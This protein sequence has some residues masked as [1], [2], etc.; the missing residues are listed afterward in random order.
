MA[1]N[2]SRHDDRALTILQSEQ[3][4][5]RRTPR[6]RLHAKGMS[7]AVARRMRRNGSSAIRL[8]AVIIC[9]VL[10][11]RAA[12]HWIVSEWLSTPPAPRP[13]RVAAPPAARSRAKDSASLVARNIFCSG[14]RSGPPGPSGD[15]EAIV[16]SELPIELVSTMFCPS[17]PAW[18]VAMLRDRSIGASEPAFYRRGMRITS[19][20]AIV[21]SV[22][23]R[24]VY[25]RR[26][27]RL[28]YLEL[29]G[30]TGPPAIAHQAGSREISCNGSSCEIERSLV[31]R[32]LAN[33][34]VLAATA[35][36][37]PGAGGLR[38][39]AIQR[40]SLL[41]QLGLQPGDVVRS[42]NKMELSSPENM[43]DILIKLRH[44]SQ[45][46]VAVERQGTRLTLDY[47]IR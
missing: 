2:R 12:A 10:S 6:N 47:T 40:G 38:L 31:E 19:T 22:L 42:V 36:V 29:D 17:D 11:G 25:V 23:T 15:G 21:A 7:V 44:A 39:E 28:E 43:L 16:R 14:C 4:A 24:R 45:L 9:A 3:H 20:D 46:S 33:P 30:S 27:G 5:R 26:H 13:R 18:S 35:R 34:V 37:S 32:T 41:A 8:V 1:A